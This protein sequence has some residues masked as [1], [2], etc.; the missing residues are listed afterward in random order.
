[1]PS[2]PVSL[3]VSLQDG[4]AHASDMDAAAGD[5]GVEIEVEVGPGAPR[6]SNSALNSIVSS[7][8]QLAQ[9]VARRELAE[10]AHVSAGVRVWFTPPPPSPVIV[11]Q[12]PPPPPLHPTG[13]RGAQPA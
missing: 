10:Y 6:P 9:G 1:M 3:R 5:L 7:A 11:V 12:R 2:N 4:S 13:R 8:L